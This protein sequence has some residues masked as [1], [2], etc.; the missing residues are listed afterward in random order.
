MIAE[1]LNIHQSRQPKCTL[2]GAG[3][4]DPGLFTLKGMKALNAADVIL[5]DALVN[6]ELLKYCPESAL[7]IFV[8]KRRGNHKYSQEE[9]NQL[10]VS[11][12]FSHGHVVRLKGGDPFVFGRGMEELAFVE[13]FGIP[14][15]IVPG[16]SSATA[17]PA[18]QK[19]PL[20]SRGVAESFWVITGTTKFGGTSPDIAL[21]AQSTATVIILMGM[22]KLEEITAVFGKYRKES[23]PVAIIQNGSLPGERICIGK[24]SDIANRSKEKGMRAP[25]II[26]IGNVVEALQKVR[27]E[28]PGTN[29]KPSLRNQW[30]NKP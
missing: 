29:R 19:I 25:A 18:L 30:Q 6:E 26:V 22:S 27:Q 1:K 5:Y 3:P 4:G 15:A 17:V 2:V 12:A 28:F 23:T 20:T 8:G 24:I 16:I 13:S 14:T 10:I 21:A 9:I 7:K 11:Y